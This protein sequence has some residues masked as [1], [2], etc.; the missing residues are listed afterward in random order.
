[1][2]TKIKICGLKTLEDIRM[3]N[4]YPI[5]YVG[6]VFVESKRKVSKEQ[7]RDMKKILSTKIKAVGVFVNTPYDEINDIVN[8]CGID[9]VQMHGEESSEECEKI[10]VPVWKAIS[11]QNKKDL[12]KA[13]RYKNVK[14][15]LL[16]G[17]K[18]GSGI[19]F[20]WSLVK[21]FSKNYFTI[22]AG[23]LNSENVQQCIE[24]V[25]PH[26]V[27][28][29]SGVEKDGQKNEEKIKKFIRKVK[30]YEFKK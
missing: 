10:I 13:Q 6:F 19:S 17:V 22:L 12:I 1:M 30:K 11:V 24:I 8:Y 28:V 21:E 15:F 4:K 2:K 26:M 14:G 23:G 7:V 5:D 29:S 20:E 18:A 27:D 25:N 9:I 3:I 16:D